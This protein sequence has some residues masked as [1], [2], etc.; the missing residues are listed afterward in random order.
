MYIKRSIEEVIKKNTEYYPVILITGPR[1]VGKTTM[2]K[3]LFSKGYDYITMDDI[4]QRNLLDEDSI[5]FFKNN[6]GKLI[7]DEIQY[8]PNS[9]ST[10]KKIVDENEEMG[11]FLLTGSQSYN[12]MKCVSESL[13]GRIAIFK[14]LGFS[15]REK[16]EIDFNDPFIPNQDYIN[17]RKSK[18]KQYAN[19]WNEI[20]RGFMPKLFKH[21]E[22]DWGIYYSSY[23]QTYIER[24]VR[25]L[26]Q[27]AD[28]NLFMKFMLSLAARSG[29]LV[30]YGAIAKD[31]GVSSETIKR[32]MSIL[33]TS[34]IIH[35]L[36]PY[37][38]NHL[39]RVIKTPKVYFLDTGLL[40]YLTKWLTPETLK[41]G[42][43]N[44]NFFE[45]FVVSEIVKSFINKG[46]TNPPLYYY[47][48]KSMREIDLVIEDGH[49]LY[50]IEIKMTA[51]PTKKMA[52]NFS[53]LKDI[54]DMN[55][56]NGTIICQYD[57]M[58]YLSENLVALPI[59]YI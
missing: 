1:Q 33:E 50:P 6:S 56:K 9:F 7:L 40:A 37:S 17:K 13:A 35:L 26:T 53:V 32:W 23:I 55:L 44:G 4:I 48:D 15:M 3:H 47:R 12:L 22:M 18:I 31:I 36:Y 34:N 46:I 21:K 42:A 14:M 59:E 58:V 25:Q 49:D 28:E 5:L 39:K 19:I 57:S 11:Y 38:H 52:D 41:V 27:V 8:I 10:I 2:L 51:K 20:H 45:T 24:D 30:N 43:Q 29:E 16:L 54:P